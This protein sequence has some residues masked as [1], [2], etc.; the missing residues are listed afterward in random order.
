MTAE[1]T[2][3]LLVNCPA[4][5]ATTK[6]SGIPMS[7]DSIHCPKCKNV[8]TIVGAKPFKEVGERS[9]S[10]S[11]GALREP[12]AE[13]Y[14]RTYK[15]VRATKKRSTMLVG[16]IVGAAVSLIIT[17]LLVFLFI[18]KKPGET[19]ESPHAQVLKQLINLYQSATEQMAQ[20]QTSVEITQF[21]SKHLST[22]N[23]IFE[24]QNKYSSLPGYNASDRDEVLSLERELTLVKDRYDQG[25]QRLAKLLEENKGLK[26][27]TTAPQP[28]LT[29]SSTPSPSST[30]SSVTSIGQQPTSMTP[31]S[32]VAS[33][34]T[35][36]KN[37]DAQ[38]HKV[39]LTLLNLPKDQLN[40][41]FLTRLQTLAGG[42]AQV[43]NRIWSGDL[44]I[45]EIGPVRDIDQL[46]ARINFGQVTRLD[47]S[48]RTMTVLVKND[49]L[50]TNPDGSTVEFT[51]DPILQAVSDLKVGTLEK[52]RVAVQ[53]IY[54]ARPN[55]HQPQVVQAL[56]GAIAEKDVLVRVTAMKALGRW[57]GQDHIDLFITLLNDESP[58]I[59][60]TS[61][62]QLSLFKLPKAAEA[63][64]KDG[65][66]KDRERASAAL[67][68]M[69][70]VAEPFVLPYLNHAEIA[71]RLEACR[72]LKKIGTRA[73]IP[74]L[75][76]ITEEAKSP[77][78]DAAWDA[79]ESI[80]SRKG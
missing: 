50:A 32:S 25:R 30:A 59:R 21:N 37:E 44:L 4:C 79:I 49:F 46:A 33:Q 61:M 31:T 74:A 19:K 13:D 56:T 1:P 5:R 7:K 77:V 47:K 28:T 70:T 40:R 36:P 9:S 18:Y 42:Q 53:T 57:G 51:T 45:I 71:L 14:K 75:L 10:S 48:L 67:Q 39:T 73:S 6:V 66:L 26:T 15:G 41:D 24:L 64:A 78:T 80:A 76:K 43:L 11:S 38:K 20:L 17:S 29:Q 69:G 62:D 12:T 3:T 63:L 72:I 16:I 8:I 52:K 68:A 35:A 55:E 23:Q 22:A 65:L 2:R 34:S 58:L 27:N 54:A 60:N